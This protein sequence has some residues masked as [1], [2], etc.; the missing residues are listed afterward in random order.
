MSRKGLLFDVE[1]CTG[2]QTCNIACKQ[3]HQ[4]KAGTF[5]I[6][7]T[8][9][10]Y[11]GQKGKVQID[12]VPFPTTLCNL[13]SERIAKGE[14]TVPTCVRHCQAQCIEYG[15]ADALIEKANSMKRPMLFL[16]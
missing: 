4:Y 3:E 14:D 1:Y 6:K 16:A 7:V 2:C 5:G 9:H 15:E 12:F 8:E 10:I 13:C 11:P